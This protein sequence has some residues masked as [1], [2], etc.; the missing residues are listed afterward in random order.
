MIN[1]P[2]AR[3]HVKD[4][5]NSTDLFRITIFKQTVPKSFT[6]TLQHKIIYANRPKYEELKI[7]KEQKMQPHMGNKA[8]SLVSQ[9]IYVRHLLM[10]YIPV[11]FLISYKIQKWENTEDIWLWTEFLLPCLLQ[12]KIYK[13]DEIKTQPSASAKLTD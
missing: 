2:P 8:R 7:K 3:H 11:F 6:R 5:M 9:Y 13:K 4:I 10:C 1:C 12:Q